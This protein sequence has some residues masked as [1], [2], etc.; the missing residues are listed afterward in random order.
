MK[1]NVEERERGEERERK[2][3]RKRHE[4]ANKRNIHTNIQRENTYKHTER[5][6][7]RK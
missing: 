5:E 6:R 7:E 2:G 3:G 1:K 4:L